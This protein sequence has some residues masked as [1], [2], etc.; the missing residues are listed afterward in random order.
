M[1]E[2]EATVGKA[3]AK[4]LTDFEKKAAA[5]AMARLAK[6]TTH[7]PTPEE[8]ELA[9]KAQ[10]ALKGCLH[11]GDVQLNEKGHFDWRDSILKWV[12]PW[13]YE[14]DTLRKYQK[15]PKIKKI[16]YINNDEGRANFME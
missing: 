11:D 4:A 2:L 13:K 10:P 8:A 16:Y 1:A 12:Q 9:E 5:D 6:V 15:D 7:F 3:V 14:E